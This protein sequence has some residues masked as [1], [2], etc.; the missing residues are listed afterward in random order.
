M[1]DERDSTSAPG[2]DAPM[3]RVIFDE[4]RGD[5]PWAAQSVEDIDAQKREGQL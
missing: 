5:G 3:M 2:A 1:P 4:R